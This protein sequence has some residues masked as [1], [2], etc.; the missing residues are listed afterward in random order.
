MQAHD[1]FEDHTQRAE[2]PCE[3]LRQVVAGDVLDHLAAG[4]REGPVGEAHGDAEQE[5]PSGSVAVPQRAGV[6]GGDDPADGGGRL[7]RRVRPSQRWVESEH[8]ADGGEDL[9]GRGQRHPRL[10]DRGEVAGVVLD[11]TVQMPGQH[12]DVGLGNGAAPAQLGAPAGRPE[13]E[14]LVRAGT[15]EL[16]RLFRGCGELLTAPHPQAGPVRGPG[17]SPAGC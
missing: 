16:R 10:Q 5:V 8:L 15:E 12:V 1:H 14:P 7:A 2:R 11:H 3:Q 6:A 9:L 13:A 17:P 4:P